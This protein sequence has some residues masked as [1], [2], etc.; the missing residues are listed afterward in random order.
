MEVD[1]T[2]LEKVMQ[3]A[4]ACQA[5]TACIMLAKILGD[6]DAAEKFA[7]EVV[8]RVK[9]NIPPKEMTPKRLV[10]EKNRILAK[11]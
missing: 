11:Y 6:K 2:K 7:D 5:Y 8:E 1:R 9:W 10:E 4:N 3:E